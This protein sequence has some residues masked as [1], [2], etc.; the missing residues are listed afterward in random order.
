MTN[1]IRGGQR[2]YDGEAV[3]IPAILVRM[4]RFSVA[5]S[6]DSKCGLPPFPFGHR[7]AGMA[8]GGKSAISTKL[9]NNMVFARDTRYPASANPTLDAIQIR[10][11]SNSAMP[12]SDRSRNTSSRYERFGISG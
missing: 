10:N 7:E 5:G 4:A 1:K 8:E 6:D 11:S 12:P 9:T 2:S 3:E